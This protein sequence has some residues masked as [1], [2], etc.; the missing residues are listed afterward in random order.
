MTADGAPCVMKKH[1]EAEMAAQL[2]HSA[3]GIALIDDA[4]ELAELL[5]PLMRQLHSVPDD[6]L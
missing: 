3:Y 6:L 4:I 1:L 5:M 2:R